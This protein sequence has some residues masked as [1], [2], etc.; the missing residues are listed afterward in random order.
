M[1]LCEARKGNQEEPER[2]G[3]RGGT[4]GLP[5]PRITRE[6]S[7]QIPDSFHFA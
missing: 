1:C 6:G 7:L 4:K 5:W 2:R 3:P